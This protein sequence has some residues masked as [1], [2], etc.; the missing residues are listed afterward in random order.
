MS[1]SCK[2]ILV[3]LSPYI[4]REL[5]AETAKAVEEHLS[6]CESCRAEYRFLSGIS[7]A[8]GAL[9]ELSVSAEFHNAL[10]EKLA[11]AA[12]E[13]NISGRRKPV[14]QWAA[15]FAAAA[16]VVALSVVTFSSL[17][18]QSELTPD[19]PAPRLTREDRTEET[20][21][22]ETTPL[23]KDEA[24]KTAAPDNRP[25][26]TQKPEQIE[27][28]EAVFNEPA[29]AEQSEDISVFENTAISEEPLQASETAE[30]LSETAEQKASGGATPE[31]ERSSISRA[32]AGGSGLAADNS[33]EALETGIA[34]QSA[35]A[36]EKTT[37]YYRL[38]GESY[39]SACTLL[40]GYQAEG[41]GF[42][43]PIEEKAVAAQQIEALPGCISHRVETEAEELTAE[44]ANLYE[45][46]VLFL[47]EEVLF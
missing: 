45:S 18:K 6:A 7:Q 12:A 19:V 24:Q 36:P 46:Y 21:P 14:W 15:G 25:G 29:S 28:E 43:V 31:S 34:L 40:S 11:A 20:A 1:K 17:P 5:D 22:K 10:H 8:A 4:D 30:K 33:A 44:E 42:L 9:P 2:E 13:K 35:S 41:N 39:I 27:T 47:L 16:A 23:P 32:A 37:L 38:T 3:L 26:N